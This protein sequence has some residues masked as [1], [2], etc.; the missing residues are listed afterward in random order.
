MSYNIKNTE[1]R[2]KEKNLSNFRIFTK[3]TKKDVKKLEKN[4]DV[5][6]LQYFQC[7]REKPTKQICKKLYN[8]SEKLSILYNLER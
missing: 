5:C 7:G 8:P 3:K 1:V 2:L 4:T 6:N